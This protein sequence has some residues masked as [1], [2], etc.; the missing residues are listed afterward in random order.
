MGFSFRRSIGEKRFLKWFSL[1]HYVQS[2]IIYAQRDNGHK[3]ICDC[4]YCFII[5]NHAVY[6]YILIL[7]DDDI[8]SHDMR[9]SGKPVR[10]FF[11]FSARR[12][13]CRLWFFKSFPAPSSSSSRKSRRLY[14]KVGTYVYIIYSRK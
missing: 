5:L 1:Q 11:G 12:R 3:S 6:I 13:R 8:L 14:K 9:I 7:Y 10:G 4:A 2:I